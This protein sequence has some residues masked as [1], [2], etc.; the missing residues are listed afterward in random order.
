MFILLSGVICGGDRGWSGC[1][2]FVGG[3]VGG[4]ED[5]GRGVG[6]GW[7]GGVVRVVVW[8]GLS[9]FC[10]CSVCFGFSLF[11]CG[12]VYGWWIVGSCLFVGGGMFVGSSKGVEG[13]N[14]RSRC[15]FLWV[16]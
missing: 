5:G 14:V 1:G 2:S 11:C 4:W 12:N 16:F 7:V 6:V 9:V 13:V 3:E 15:C 8:V 10:F